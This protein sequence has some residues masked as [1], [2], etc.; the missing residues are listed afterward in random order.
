MPTRPE[1]PLTPDQ[2]RAARMLADG[3]TGARTARALDVRPE[4]VSRWNRNPVF[5]AELG[6]ALELAHRGDTRQRVEALTGP[7]LDALASVLAL[8]HAIPALRIQ[9]AAA[10]LHFAAAIRDPNEGAPD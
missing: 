10:L 1:R 7:A 8:P 9:A 3:W 2:I 5:R 6:R 4:T